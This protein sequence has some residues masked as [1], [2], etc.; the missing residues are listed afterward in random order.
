M[1]T[2]ILSLL[3]G[4]LSISTYSEFSE[5]ESSRPPHDCLP[6][7]RL[8]IFC[9]GSLHTVSSNVI[10]SRLRFL[11]Y[12]LLATPFNG[13]S[14]NKGNGKLKRKMNRNLKRKWLKYGN[15]RQQPH[16]HMRNH[17]L[18]VLVER[19]NRCVEIELIPSNPVCIRIFCTK[20][21]MLFSL[22]SSCH[23]QQLWG[24]RPANKS[25]TQFAVKTLLFHD[26]LGCSVNRVNVLDD[27]T[28]G[29]SE[30]CDSRLVSNYDSANVFNDI[31]HA[32]IT[33]EDVLATVKIMNSPI[34]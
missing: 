21:I 15:G 8:Y 18:E 34:K 2:Y 3:L 22:V 24:A 31:K 6:K 33:S 27:S 23:F 13:A 20:M 1:Y 7:L 11:K 30:S 25:I 5:T 29:A 12:L 4:R 14:G 26:K 10:H 17:W 32:S 16:S 28:D 9:F 19:W